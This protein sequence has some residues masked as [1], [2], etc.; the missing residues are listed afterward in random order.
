MIYMPSAVTGKAWKFARP[1][2]GP[3]GLQVSPLQ[4]L[5]LDLLMI[6]M[7]KQSLLQQSLSQLTESDPAIQSRHFVER[8]TKEEE[9]QFHA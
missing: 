5:K 9:E 6:R 7:Q 4:M 1:F 2:H 3:T 8:A